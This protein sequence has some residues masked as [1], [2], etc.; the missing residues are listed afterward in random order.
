MKKVIVSLLLVM[1]MGVNPI[2]LASSAPKH[3][4]QSSVAQVDKTTSSAQDDEDALEAYSDTTSVDSIDVDSDSNNAPN[5]HSQ[6][7][8]D[9]YD[10]PFD[11]IGSVFGKG[12]LA[13]LSIIISLFAILFLLGP[14]IVVIII[15]RYL[16]HR[17]NDHMKLAE[18]AM[19]KG[20]NIPESSRPIDRQSEEY[21]LKRGIRNTFLG[22]GLFVM[23]AIWGSKILS[24][25]SVLVFFYGVGQL[26]IGL[27]PTIKKFYKNNFGEK[28]TFEQGDFNMNNNSEVSD[29]Q[30][31]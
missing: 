16:Y 15:V 23:F 30:E 27:L 17:H 9:N 12:A 8:L 31:D 25:F 24:G 4:Y 5:K 11:F 28:T 10:D 2:S 7:S 1:S 18:M 6:Y 21:L 3:R 14:L 22:L 20:V 26:V 13:C 29:Q 19:E